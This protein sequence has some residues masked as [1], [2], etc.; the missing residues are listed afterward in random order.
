MS[1]RK[2]RNGGSRMTSGAAEQTGVEG[3]R[4]DRREPS[5]EGDW[6]DQAAQA[7]TADDPRA[8]A[9]HDATGT[10]STG[11]RPGAPLGVR[12]STGHDRPNE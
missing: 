12:P 4:E 11:D 9:P 7:R 3:T 1:R 6:A 2:S 8:M 5:D 10:P